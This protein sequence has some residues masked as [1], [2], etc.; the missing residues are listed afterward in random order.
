MMTTAFKIDLMDP[1][2][3]MYELTSQRRTPTTT[4]TN[5][6]WTKGMIY[7]FFCLDFRPV[8]HSFNNFGD[9]TSDEAAAHRHLSKNAPWNLLFEF[10]PQSLPRFSI[11]ACSKHDFCESQLFPG[12]KACQ[13]RLC[14]SLGL[15]HQEKTNV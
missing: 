13:P 14:N 12:F 6:T 5:T 4:R 9:W 2:I 7:S 8:R 1:A 11:I 10:T 15:S 3:G